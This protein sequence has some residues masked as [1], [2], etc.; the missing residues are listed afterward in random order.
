MRDL[1][2]EVYKSIRECSTEIIK[3]SIL[4]APLLAKK[5]K[6]D[7]D[8]ETIKMYLKNFDSLVEIDFNNWEVACRLASDGHI[9]KQRFIDLYGS[10]LVGLF[11]NDMFKEKINK[12]RYSEI[13]KIVPEINGKRRF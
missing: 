4:M 5:E 11:F 8:K 9:N 13:N 10:N 12:G 2:F 7:E 6:T 1:E 3:S